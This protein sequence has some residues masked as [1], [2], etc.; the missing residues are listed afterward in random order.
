M[1]LNSSCSPGRVRWEPGSL[2]LLLGVLQD[3]QRA[4]DGG[5]SLRKLRCSQVKFYLIFKR[6]YKYTVTCLR[7]K[8]EISASLSRPLG[9]NVT[10]LHWPVAGDGHHYGVGEAWSDTEL[11]LLQG[12]PENDYCT[13][14]RS[15]QSE[16]NVARKVSS[17]TKI[18]RFA[19]RNPG[20]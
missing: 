19:L 15:W 7:L 20:I 6:F 10:S 12:L 8:G 2:V 3:S 4:S 11:G 5:W 16:P 14:A 17:S 18:K 9:E 13:A 1:D